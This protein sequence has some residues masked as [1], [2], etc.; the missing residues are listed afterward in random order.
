MTVN[1]NFFINIYI[2][3]GYLPYKFNFYETT[4]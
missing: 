2:K 1:E 4:V 3:L